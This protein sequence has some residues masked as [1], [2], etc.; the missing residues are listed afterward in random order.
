[1]EN[2]IDQNQE[3]AALKHENRS[4]FVEMKE[5]KATLN[6]E[7]EVKEKTIEKLKQKLEERDGTIS[8]YR[9]VYEAIEREACGLKQKLEDVSQWKQKAGLLSTVKHI[10]ETMQIKEL[11]S[12][13]SEP[14]NK[15]DIKG[16]EISEE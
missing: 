3:I 12:E 15:L 10:S 8:F 9:G 6:V 5:L 1:M 11:Q 2:E 16:I 7:L 14:K 4:L 13:V